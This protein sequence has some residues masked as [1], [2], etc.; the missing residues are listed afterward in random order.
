MAANDEFQEALD[1]QEKTHRA[2][3]L[4]VYDGDTKQTITV[5]DIICEGPIAGLVDGQSSVFLNDDRAIPLAVGSEN[6]GG[7]E[8]G[9]P[10]IT[11]TN[12]SNSGTVENLTE[13]QW[14]V[15]APDSIPN[16]HL[17]VKNVFNV[18]TVSVKTYADFIADT[19]DPRHLRVVYDNLGVY[20]KS[21]LVDITRMAFGT[22][23]PDRWYNYVPVRLVAK[24]NAPGDD[25]RDSISG[26]LLHTL[27]DTARRPHPSYG[28]F[29]QGAIFVPGSYGRFA[30]GALGIPAGDYELEIDQIVALSS[31]LPIQFVA[32]KPVL[33]LAENWPETTGD[34]YFNLVSGT[35]D[36]PPPEDT[37]E[38][39]TYTGTQTQFRTGRKLQPPFS[40]LRGGEGASSVTNSNPAAGGSIEW[41]TGFGGSQAAKVLVGS[42]STG[43]NLSA[44]Q[45][46]EVDEIRISFQYPGGL[47]A[48]NGDGRTVDT[49]A[50]YK[51]E[52]GLK[53]NA[54][55]DFEDYFVVDDPHEHYSKSKSALT[56]Q[57]SIDMQKYKPFSDFRVRISRKTDHEGDGYHTDGTRRDGWTNISSSNIAS[58]TSVIKEP[59]YYPY[60]ALARVSY[61]TGSFQD[62]P[63][64]SYH[65]R[66]A[67]VRVPSNYFTREE[68]SSNQAEY[69]RNTSTGVKE[70]TYQDWDGNFRPTLVYT[71]N[72]AWVF[73]DILVNNRYG[74]GN[75]LEKADIDIYQLY[76]IG[77]YCDELVDDGTGSGVLEPRFTCNLFLTKQVDAFKVLKDML[78]VFRGM[79][80][81]IDGQVCP[82][83]DAP[84]G[85]VYNFSKANVLNGSFRYEGTGSKT[86]INQVNVTWNNPDKNY[87]QEVLLVEDRANIAKTGK[88]ISQ[89]SMA[90]GCTS[91]GQARRYGRWKL[92]TAAN[93]TEII[94][95]ATGLNGAFLRPG[96]V[97]N[98]QDADKAGVRFSGRIGSN[99]ETGLTVSHTHSSGQIASD[100]DGFD[101]TDRTNNVV[102][103]GEA[104]LPSSFSQD[105]CL[106]EYGASGQGVWIGVRQISS[107]YNFVFRTG[108]GDSVVTAS[109]G[110]TIIGEIPVDEIPEFDGGSHTIA[111]EIQ[112]DNGEAYLWIDGRLVFELETTDSSALEAGVWA[113]SNVG[114]WGEGFGATAGGYAL[115]AWSG[116]IQSDLRVY[117]SQITTDKITLDSPVTLNATSTYKLSVVFVEPGAFLAQDT[118]T[119]NSVTYNRGDLIKQAFIDSN[120]DGTYTLQDITSDDFVSNAKASASD[121]DAL[122]LTWSE[123]LRVEEQTI[124]NNGSNLTHLT[125][126]AA[127]ENVP[128]RSHIWVI[129]EI[130]DSGNITTSSK[131][132]YRILSITEKS[133]D[134][135]EITGVRYYDEKYSAVEEDFT[136]YVS[137]SVYTDVKATDIVPKPVG[138]T[139]SS[140]PGTGYDATNVIVSWSAPEDPNDANDD[141]EHLTG[142]MIEHNI[143]GRNPNQRVGRD[144]RSF[145][146]TNVPSGKHIFAVRTI[147]K[148][149]NLSEAVVESIEII[150]GNDITD[151]FNDGFFPPGVRYGGFLS[152]RTFIS[153]NKNFRVPSSY[154]FQAT[155][156]SQKYTATVLNNTDARGV[157]DVSGMPSITYSGN[158][159]TGFEYDIFYML[160]DVS[161]TT[162]PL[163]LC[164]IYRQEGVTY[165]YD[166][167]TGSGTTRTGSNLTG[168]VSG[169]K[170]NSR[171]ILTGSGTSFTTELVKGDVI[172]KASGEVLGVVQSI[173]SDTQLTLDRRL[174]A[175]VSSIN[176]KIPNIRIDKAND[177]FIA[178][179]YNNQGTIEMRPLTTID[180]SIHT[181]QGKRTAGL[182]HYW[183]G[184]SVQG[185]KLVDTVGSVAA[186]AFGT[187]PTVSN[188]SPVGKSFQNDDGIQILPASAAATIEQGSEG[189]THSI[190][191]KSESS[192]GNANARIFDRDFDGKYAFVVDQ[193]EAADNLQDAKIYVV[194]SANTTFTDAILYN[195][196]NHVGIIFDG[197][198]FSVYINGEEV[199]AESGYSPTSSTHFINVGINDAGTGNRFVGKFT[200]I[201]TYSNA[202]S[203]DEIYA[204]YNNPAATTAPVV[205]QPIQ[206]GDTDGDVFKVTS[207]GIALGNTTFASA[208]FRVD[209]AGNLTA[210]SGT[211]TGSVTAASFLGGQPVQQTLEE[212]DTLRN[213]MIAPRVSMRG[214]TVQ[215]AILEDN[216][217]IYK[218]DE[219]IK[220]TQSAGTRNNFSTAIGDILTSDRPC[221]L[222]T[223]QGPL[224]SL[225]QTG[226][227]F[228]TVSGSGTSQN[229]FLYSPYGA[230]AA[231]VFSAATSTP[232][233]SGGGTLIDWDD[234]NQQDATYVATLLQSGYKY[235]IVTTGTTDFTAIGA[236]DSNPGTQFVATGA[237]TGDGTAKIVEGW[238]NVAIAAETVT[239]HNITTTNGVK[240]FTWFKTDSPVVMYRNSSGQDQTI[241]RPAS[242]E[243]F[244]YD[245]YDEVKFDPS[246]TETTTT[247]TAITDW[248]YHR[249]TSVKLGSF[250]NGDGSGADGTSHFPWSFAGD[251]YCLAHALKGY[252]IATIEPSIVNVYYWSG[253]AWTLYKSH[254][255]SAASREN[256]LGVAEGSNDYEGGTDLGSGATAWRFTG[257]GR[258]VLRSNTTSPLPGNDEYFAIGYDS[259]LRPENTIRAG[260]IIAGDIAADAITADAIAANAITADAVA[261]GSIAVNKLTGDVTETYPLKIEPNDVLSSSS[262]F[263][264]SFSIPAPSLSVSKRQ[265]VNATIEVNVGNSDSS[266]VQVGKFFIGVQKKSKGASSVSLGTMTIDSGKFYVSGN[267]LNLADTT[268]AISNDSDGSGGFVSI[269][270]LYYDL[271]NDRTYFTPGPGSV[272]F[273]NGATL[274][275]NQDSF[276][277]AGTFST[278]GSVTDYQIPVDHS[279]NT[280]ITIPYDA[281]FGFSTTGTEFRLTYRT[282]IVNSSITVTVNTVQGTLENIA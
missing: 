207:D 272:T 75:F 250:D 93:Q 99:V 153:Q 92:W 229:Y 269:G 80:Y 159:G 118:A 169:T 228:C 121:T 271:T 28:G 257:T 73:Y 210:T 51:V 232:T 223:N 134:N 46:E 244:T 81:Y 247:S 183:P 259:N 149:G 128:Q 104:I 90:F 18:P 38:L 48:I 138:V 76:R 238:T 162:D 167:G 1:D 23:N 31:N 53:I 103:A 129:Q 97:V 218:N 50:Q 230:T 56:F 176:I 201:K 170:N 158:D 27:D 157:Q 189:F 231:R 85:P 205:D 13:E 112:P 152:G 147:N 222:Q 115:T 71:N 184:N 279:L 64:R 186:T 224:P 166:T 151:G 239:E 109:D 12:G 94:T 180:T 141:Y 245:G 42:G 77:R 62:V 135:Y 236:A 263:S 72:P 58:V 98:V 260:K 122:Q 70:S 47:Y 214:G 179:L 142:F 252:Q 65:V 206:I 132:P 197:T 16:R 91:E 194:G 110:N 35:D 30:G 140:F 139:V 276:L 199:Y 57:P 216:T 130:D 280:I 212:R 44:D 208:P 226:T 59:V 262:Q 148:L 187:P 235:E 177:S 221:M 6:Y 20:I 203:D 137:D 2:L 254:D 195:Q 237:G 173:S 19:Y 60:T 256:F 123:Y 209:M 39:A 156:N 198:I 113:G 52:L 107:E 144:R 68:L 164:K 191:F 100:G 258:F 188:D 25:V 160:F 55:E 202:L 281:T 192:S 243:I 105:E 61:N 7:G 106:F 78:T 45:I 49:V 146:F 154:T 89:D 172:H 88:I 282:T 273:T 219:V 196:W 41:T 200:E 174:T 125:T 36:N 220:L 241:V 275:Y 217:T 17:I 40:S 34:Y 145:T 234:H 246:N 251:T 267:K 33:G 8:Q 215:Y 37:S 163:K 117:N 69:T 83:Y 227:E 175:D 143:P 11:L 171:A 82:Q 114:G 204:E 124:S 74:L 131:L 101:A 178:A 29:E 84:S 108:D 66:G 21:P 270:E 86:R 255:L 133:A 265:R 3:N 190:W 116:S 4:G 15:T 102:M 277:S 155:G 161:D 242:R 211:F 274:Y 96:D 268:G 14:N 120:D 9:I 266:G 193:S 240:E 32:D 136:T 213:A 185:T 5:T 63:K 181:D 127:F 126:S 111:W 43:F 225:A 22:G 261:A 150:P 95:F 24:T 87:E 264:D 168:T 67:L 165:W 119:I 10:Y 54:T 182:A 253:S 79:L 249:N 233:K 278:V 26:W 248:G